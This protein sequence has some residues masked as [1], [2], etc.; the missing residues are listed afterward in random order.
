MT[1]AK[2]SESVI[3]TRKYLQIIANHRDSLLQIKGMC[4]DPKVDMENSQILAAQVWRICRD[5]LAY[6]RP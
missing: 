4:E 3:E 1:E 6:H 5:S 2:I